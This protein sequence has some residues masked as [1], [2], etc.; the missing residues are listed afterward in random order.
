MYKSLFFIFSLIFLPFSA[1]DIQHDKPPFGLSVEQA[2]AWQ[3]SSKLAD[4]N[5]ISQVTL[6][7]RFTAKASQLNPALNPNVKVLLAPDGMN[8]LANYLSEQSRFNLYNFTHW[9]QI[10][11]LNWFAGTADLTVNLPARPWV[12]A[13]HKNGVKVI[14][15]IY[16]AVA[17]WGGS[18]D[19]AERFLLRDDKGRFPMAHQLVKMAEY[20]GFDGWLMNQETDL[21]AVKND[22][23]ELVKGVKDYN[24]AQQ[25]GREMLAFMTYLNH[26]APQEME[27]HWY[28][29]QLI[30]GT[31]RWQNELNEK[32]APFFGHKTAPTSDAIFL[33]YWWN[34]KMVQSSHDFAKKLKRD[35]YMVYTGAD[36]WPTR[37]AQK[38]F[39]NNTWL[40]DIFSDPQK[41]G[42]TSIALFGNNVNYP[43][44]KAV[45]EY[46][47]FAQ[48]PSDYRRFYDVETRLFAGDD[49][50]MATHQETWKGISQYIPAKSVL[51][52]LPFTTHFNTGHGLAKFELG[53]QVNTRPWHNMSTQDILPSWQ[54]AV[55]GDI[56]IKLSYDF[57]QAY[58]G[59]SS[60]KI[61]ANKVNQ[62]SYIPL[63]HTQFTLQENTKLTVQH[64]SPV[65][66]AK[67]SLLLEF[68]DKSKR[69]IQLEPSAKWLSKVHSIAEEAGKVVTRI[70]LEVNKNNRDLTL[71]V[72]GIHLE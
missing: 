44:G 6:A 13:A 49:L 57:E 43:G 3:P 21:S 5:N 40:N 23:N 27:I 19:T 2:L 41:Q 39:I 38:I 56:D 18:A 46:S 25:L 26:I 68:R 4:S 14:G 54:F 42:L 33:N 32:N 63:Y 61:R 31:V 52:D 37:N 50:N 70:S 51:S 29:A 12:E 1:A 65:S 35:P 69:R 72:G 24:R 55:Y 30:D 34:K 7:P 59:G 47:T 53:S 16:L 48:D 67:A 45:E 60:L 10:D 8:N 66:S 20:Y 71:N 64:Q 11:V 62:N 9:S 22:K 58:H 36:L 28:D 17:Q 15:T